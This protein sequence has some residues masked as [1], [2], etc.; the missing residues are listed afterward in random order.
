MLVP[1]APA[2]GLSEVL[3]DDTERWGVR[4]DPP[5]DVREA[6]KHTFITTNFGAGAVTASFRERARAGARD[7]RLR[8]PRRERNDHIVTRDTFPRPALGR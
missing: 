7:R 4:P 1:P 6:H 8:A 5:L 3:P 2:L